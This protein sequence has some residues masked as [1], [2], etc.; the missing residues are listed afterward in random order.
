[1]GYQHLRR[2]GGDHTGVRLQ[3]ARVGACRHAVS[4]SHDAVGLAFHVAAEPHDSCGL[5]LE[6]DIDLA[7][8]L[9]RQ[10]W[11]ASPL[12][13]ERRSRRTHS[14]SAQVRRWRASRRAAT[15]RLVRS[16]ARHAHAQIGAL[17][18]PPARF[19]DDPADVD[20]TA[21]RLARLTA[22]ALIERVAER[23]DCA[24]ER[25][26]REGRCRPPRAAQGPG[27]V[28]ARLLRQS[29][30]S[31]RDPASPRRPVEPPRPS[32][33]RRPDG[34][35]LDTGRGGSAGHRQGPP[36]RGLTST[37]RRR[38]GPP[39]RRWAD[40]ARRCGL[41]CAMLDPIVGEA[42]PHALPGCA[43]QLDAAARSLALRK[44]SRSA[45]IWSLWVE[46]MPCG[47]PGYTFSVAPLTSLEER[48]AEAPIGTI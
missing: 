45:L 7:G 32:P 35:P 4:V 1:M 29:D 10:P 15:T 26:R 5:V 8:V 24:A 44:A 41:P 34:P 22:R 27:R 6:F 19:S 20:F 36:C 38:R 16:Q 31:L 21:S 25:R 30:R 18:R 47:N 23:R 48:S 28:L 9:A 39:S 14:P 2:C 46:H 17:W 42:L 3:V 11:D 43:A 13:A 12:R 37:L 33:G 40:A